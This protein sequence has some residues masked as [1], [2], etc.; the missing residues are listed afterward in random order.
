MDP[1]AVL[2]TLHKVVVNLAV[3]GFCG[4]VL[5][6][7]TILKTKALH[8]V[9]NYMLLNLAIADAF[10]G[11]QSTLGA[12]IME[13]HRRGIGTSGYCTPV[14]IYN[15]KLFFMFVYLKKISFA[16]S[17]FSLTLATFE[18]Y[19]G[20]IK[21]LH[22][23]TFFT[24]RR[25]IIMLLFV[26]L[27]PFLTEAY[28]PIFYIPMY[29]QDNCT[30]P[31]MENYP[32][33]MTSGILHFIFFFIIPCISLAFMYVRILINLK[34]GARHL[35]NQ[36]IQGPPQELLRAHKKVTKSLLLVVA[37]FFIL[38][39][40]GQLLENIILYSSM[41]DEYYIFAELL[42]QTISILELLNS[43]I[44]PILYGFKYSQL[45]R[46]CVS[47]LCPC[48]HHSKRS[49]QVV[50]SQQVASVTT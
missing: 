1:F 29:I 22:Y 23:S 33:V 18:R 16:N 36:G 3:V 44:N 14:F 17:V 8:N 13:T 4:N 12:T 50:H 25:L 35:E 40:P 47:M 26:W 11:I 46:A 31:S 39:L 6:F 42:S 43:T 49:N 37:A 34:Q 2:W 28:T 24:K 9:T 7:L 48:A 5:V 21:P 15:F 19:I 30:I 38:M 10:V 27:V 45:R 32:M 20:I 41:F